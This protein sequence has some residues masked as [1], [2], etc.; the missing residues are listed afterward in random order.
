MASSSVDPSSSKA[1]YFMAQNDKE[2]D[3]WIEAI[4]RAK[5]V[6]ILRVCLL[7]F[8]ERGLVMSSTHNLKSKCYS[9]VCGKH[10]SSALCEVV[11]PPGRRFE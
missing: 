7:F 4:S 5:S 2:R 6:R 8:V 11:V 10:V 9:L 1:H 3:S